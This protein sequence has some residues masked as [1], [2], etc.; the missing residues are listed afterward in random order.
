M[1]KPK[2]KDAPLNMQRAESPYPQLAFWGPDVTVKRLDRDLVCDVLEKIMTEHP[3]VI[4]M[5]TR[6]D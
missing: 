6:E 5:E 3:E 1:A 4:P 2:L